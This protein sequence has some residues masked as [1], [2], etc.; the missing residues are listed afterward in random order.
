M[1]R[2]PIRKRARYNVADLIKRRGR[3]RSTRTMFAGLMFHSRMEANYAAQLDLR[4][5]AIGPD[6]IVSWRSQ[7]PIKL[8]VNGKLICKYVA[9]FEVTFPDGHTELHE[10]KGFETQLWRIKEKLFRA[11]FPDRRLVVIR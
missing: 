11:L 6:R 5:Q 8:E 3:G 9:D 4:K 1:E 2:T 7:V 10:T